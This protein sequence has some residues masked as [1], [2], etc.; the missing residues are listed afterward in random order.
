MYNDITGD[1]WCQTAECT[2]AAEVSKVQDTLDGSCKTA[3]SERSVY[4]HG[5]WVL[6]Y[7]WLFYTLVGCVIGRTC[8]VLMFTIAPRCVDTFFWF[9]GYNYESDCQL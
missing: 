9:F 3:L 2:L 7:W 5:G 4:Q 8:L 1:C 6:V